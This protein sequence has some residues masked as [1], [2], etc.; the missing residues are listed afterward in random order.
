MRRRILQSTL[1]VAAVAV[2]LLGVPLAVA[3]MVVARQDAERAAEALAESVGQTVGERLAEG[4]PVDPAALRAPPGYYVEIRVSGQAPV[5]I[6]RLP[7]GGSIRGE[8][9]GGSHAVTVL[10]PRSAAYARMVRVALVVPLVAALSGAAAVALGL[11]QARRLAE[12]LVDLAHRAG[13]LGSG[14]ARPFARYG[15]EEVDRVAEVLERSA[16]R[17]AALLASERQFATDASHQLRTPLTALS[18]RLEE[19]LHAGDA[20]DSDTVREEARVALGQ[21]ERLAATVEH[22]LASKRRTRSATAVPLSLDDVLEQQVAEWRP[23]FDA[24][25]RRVELQGLRGLHACATPGGVSQ[26]VATLLENSLSHGEGTVTLRTRLVNGSAVVEVTDEGPGVPDDL[27]Q[28]VFERSVSGR[29]STGLGLA[30]ARDLAVAD[31]GRL[32]LLSARP[33]VF[34]LFLGLPAPEPVPA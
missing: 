32:E 34:A 5:V 21:V 23:A 14:E 15:V 13:R 2:L 20:G 12:P 19:I 4:A 31:G 9:V 27:G 18:M 17:V 6:G 22:L 7:S 16:E 26:V 28:R 33:P 25:R 8:Y 3:G 1:A 24:A 29:S 11:R 30:L 10:R